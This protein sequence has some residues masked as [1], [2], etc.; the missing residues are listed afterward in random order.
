LRWPDPRLFAR[1]KGQPR[2]KP[3]LEALPSSQ[4]PTT[5]ARATILNQR[6]AHQSPLRRGTLARLRS[7]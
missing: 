4:T 1:S 6:D 3:K 5:C 2:G 7:D